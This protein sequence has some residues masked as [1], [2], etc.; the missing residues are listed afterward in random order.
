MQRPHLQNLQ[1]P[2]LVWQSDLNLHL[3]APWPQE[4]LIKHVLP[5]ADM[6]VRKAIDRILIKAMQVAIRLTPR[7]SQVSHHTPGCRRE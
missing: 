4:R 1:A 6:F 2:R 5:S 7:I 3:Q